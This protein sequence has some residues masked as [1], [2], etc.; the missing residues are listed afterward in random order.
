MPATITKPVPKTDHV[1]GAPW[2]VDA[3]ADYLS[4]S[5]KHVRR[6]IADGRIRAIRVGVRVLVPDT[7]LQ[8]VAN[9][10]C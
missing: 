6:L 1:P 5:A 8:R 4:V 3:A 10:G 9:E 7:E 2:E